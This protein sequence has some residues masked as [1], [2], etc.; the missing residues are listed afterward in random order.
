MSQD[1]LQN[2]EPDENPA[3]LSPAA[4]KVDRANRSAIFAGLT[5]TILV[6][7][8]ALLN[9]KPAT[10]PVDPAQQVRDRPA[11]A[12]STAPFREQA[13][14]QLRRSRS[15]FFWE[16]AS[17]DP[18]SG[19]AL[20]SSPSRPPE[21]AGASPRPSVLTSL[22]PAGART[23]QTLRPPT[24]TISSA[25]SSG[26]PTPPYP[27]STA[28]PAPA[29]QATPPRDELYADQQ[30]R[31][32]LDQAGQVGPMIVADRRP[33]ELLQLR[34]GSAIGA[35]LKTQITSDLPGTVVAEVREDVYDSVTGRHLLI[36]AGSLLYGFYNSAVVWGERRVLLAF[37]RLS[38]PDGTHVDIGTQ[39]ATDG[40]GAAGLGDRVNNHWGRIIGT[41]GVLAV[42]GAAT[43]SAFDDRRS[44]LEAR[45]F[46]DTAGR[47]AAAQL[48][49]SASQLLQRN[50]NIAPT[51]RVR[52]GFSFRVVLSNDLAFPDAYEPMYPEYAP[53]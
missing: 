39:L 46:G 12:T 13:D 50:L 24:S 48:N 10:P 14:R 11:E 37:T 3:D 30:A 27:G 19:S 40:L 21:Q 7:A 5:L 53:R 23:A 33:L 16:E 9:L 36:P 8:A 41:A 31:A 17:Q 47:G 38:F 43:S 34:A 15:P 2:L 22:P 51:L 32:F 44:A 26:R 49:Q 18:A 20:S 45:D 1:D 52:T 6:V 35:N 28:E 42:I 29:A 25:P 4:P